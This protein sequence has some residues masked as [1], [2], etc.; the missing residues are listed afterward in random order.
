MWLPRAKWCRTG[1]AF[2]GPAGAASFGPKLDGMPFI[3]LLA[4][5]RPIAKLE[6]VTQQRAKHWID[7]FLNFYHC[8]HNTKQF[9]FTPNFVKLMKSRTRRHDQ[10]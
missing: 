10:W 3:T 1:L 4:V 6:P 2:L 9:E 5:S 7:K 8:Q